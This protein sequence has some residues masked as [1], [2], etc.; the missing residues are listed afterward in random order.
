Q[1]ATMLYRIEG[2]PE[3]TYESK[4]QDVPENQWF[5]NGILWANSAEIVSGYRDSG[6]FGTED[7]ITREQMAVMMYQYGKYKEYDTS[8]RGEL[9][10]F[11][12]IESL[13]NYA[14]EAM[15]WAVK[16][17][18]ISGKTGNMLDP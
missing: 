8:A 7:S 9:G 4:F 3:I 13:D 10:H 18:I 2:E 11:M 12:D 17:E 14:V 16:A 1:F 6:I 5:T 15:Q